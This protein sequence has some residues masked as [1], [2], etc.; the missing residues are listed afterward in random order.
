M[1]SLVRCAAG[2]HQYDSERYSIC[3][4][5]QNASVSLDDPT[6]P[7]SKDVSENIEPTRPMDTPAADDEVTKP[8]RD[9]PGDDDVTRPMREPAE[10]IL[11]DS[12]SDTEE[13]VTRLFRTGK[14]DIKPVTGWLV[15]IEGPGT[16]A[17]LPIYHGL[18]TVGR[19]PESQIR[20]EFGDGSDAEIS[21]TEQARLTYDPK[22]NRFYLQHGDAANLTYLN[23]E[24][25]LEL[26]TLNAYDR[27]SMGKTVMIF[28]PFCGD[29][30]QWPE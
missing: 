4:Y 5:C 16:G 9:L 7:V 6:E 1:T 14:S 18:N 24:P 20:L 25:V 19:S 28:I 12:G 8:M 11:P 27:V 26:K 10:S 13:E 17:S 22:G 3:P 15:V 23:D 21:R 29:Q 30:F 2:L